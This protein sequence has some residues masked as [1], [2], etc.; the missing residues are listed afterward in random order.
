MDSAVDIMLR[1]AASLQNPYKLLQNLI[2]TSYPYWKYISCQINPAA[3]LKSKKK[4]F[5][6][7][8]IR[9][10]TS[11]LRKH[12]IIIMKKTRAWLR[13]E[14]NSTNMITPIHLKKNL[15]NT[16][17]QNMKIIGYTEYGVSQVKALKTNTQSRLNYL[18]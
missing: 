16:H 15:V 4:N 17:T 8:Q 13:K 1:L 2:Q 10:P 5:N 12:Y 11:S 3:Y 9:M 18:Y 14:F 7:Y 6:L